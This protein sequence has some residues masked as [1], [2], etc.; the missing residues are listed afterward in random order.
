MGVFIQDE[1]DA[2][3]REN[4]VKK[5]IPDSKLHKKLQVLLFF[6]KYYKNNYQNVSVTTLQIL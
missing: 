6:Y 1:V 2:P 4:N 5:T 3:L